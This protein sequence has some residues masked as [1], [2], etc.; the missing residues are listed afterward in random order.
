MGKK[1]ASHRDA[2]FFIDM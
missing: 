1:A 2:A